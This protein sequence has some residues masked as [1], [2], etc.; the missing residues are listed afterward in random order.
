MSD[1][2]LLYAG[3]SATTGN[4]LGEWLKEHGM[5]IEYGADPGEHRY[6]GVI[7]WGSVARIPLRPERV[8]NRLDALKRATNKRQALL[9]MQAAGIPTPPLYLLDSPEIKFP[10]LGRAPEHTHGTD[11]VPCWQRADLAMAVA[12]GCDHFT[13]YIPTARELRIHVFDGNVVKISEKRL[14]E[15]E[16]W[17]PWL[18]NL[19][20]G[21]TFHTPVDRPRATTRYRAIEA[22]ELLGLHFGAVDLVEGDDGNPYV[23]E[24][25]T[26]PGLTTDSSLEA[27]GQHI[28]QT[29]A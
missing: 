17:S 18:R 22:V 19:D 15:P 6:K 25:N 16:K 28:M 8:L 24:V 13:G 11:I 14:T 7:R 23:L 1:Y 27:Y 4:E 21:Y 10:V 29:F 5:D 2:Y 20:T 9:D 12:R 26:A 3:A